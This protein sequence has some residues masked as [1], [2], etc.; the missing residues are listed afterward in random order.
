MSQQ[1]QIWH[2]LWISGIT[3][4]LVAQAAWAQVTS[5]TDIRLVSTDAGLEIRL[6]TATGESL[7][8]LTT[9]EGNRLII[10]IPNAQLQLLDGRDFRQDNPI[11]GITAVTATSIAPNTVQVI[12]IGATQPPTAQVQET[13]EGLTIQVSPTS[14]I[15]QPPSED[16]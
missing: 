9:R 6:D 16:V 3:S 13:F 15:A 14:A 1:Q 11:E 2:S 10:N 4:V 7:E 8:T 12:V 5:V